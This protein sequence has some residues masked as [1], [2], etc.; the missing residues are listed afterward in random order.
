MFIFD[1]QREMSVGDS[2]W[3]PLSWRGQLKPEARPSVWHALRER[4]RLDLVQLGETHCTRMSALVHTGVYACTHVIH[5]AHTCSAHG[6]LVIHTHMYAHVGTQGHAGTH[7]HLA[8]LVTCA[9]T[10][11]HAQAQIHPYARNQACVCHTHLRAQ[12]SRATCAVHTP[13]R[14]LG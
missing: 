12:A 6:C 8:D 1:A 2:V 5:R 4:L 3:G 13:C 7:E 11:T 9:Y 10:Y 14:L